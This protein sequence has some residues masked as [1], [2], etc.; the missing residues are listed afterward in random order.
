MTDDGS[1]P[2]PLELYAAPGA[3]A[4]GRLFATFLLANWIVM[5]W[6]V[7][8]SP[9]RAVSVVAFLM[10]MVTL[11]GGLSQLRASRLASR[12]PLIEIGPEL[13]RFRSYTNAKWR[14]VPRRSILGV[15][16]R[17]RTTLTLK[18]TDGDELVPWTA[19]GD[20]QRER[21]LGALGAG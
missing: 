11:I 9:S 10:G 4:R 2:A 14:E 20:E 18:T 6:F 7:F 19:L 12:V 21:L 8:R 5:G 1:A 16:E 15:R 13:L 3:A 17:S